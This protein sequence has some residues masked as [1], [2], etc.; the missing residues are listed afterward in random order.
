MTRETVIN[1]TPAWRATS[2]SVTLLYIDER[3][4]TVS[5]TVSAHVIVASIDFTV[6]TRDQAL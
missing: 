5:V 4:P 3:I 6:N 2:D 1:E